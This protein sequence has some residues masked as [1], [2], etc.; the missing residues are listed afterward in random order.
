VLPIV[1]AYIV[2]YQASLVTGLDRERITG[3]APEELR[4]EDGNPLS[5][6]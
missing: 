1:G 4:L 6:Q 3:V 5:T 2:G